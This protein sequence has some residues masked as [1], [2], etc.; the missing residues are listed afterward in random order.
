MNKKGAKNNG[1][2]EREKIICQESMQ[3]TL[4]WNVALNGLR[5][6]VGAIGKT[7]RPIQILAAEISIS[8]QGQPN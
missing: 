2:R 5:L 1:M 3:M 6:L 7:N 4:N 8:L